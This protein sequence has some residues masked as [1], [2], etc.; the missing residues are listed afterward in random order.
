MR[1][2]ESCAIKPPLP[3]ASGQ[4]QKV[5]QPNFVIIAIFVFFA[6]NSFFV[7]ACRAGILALFRGNSL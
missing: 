2:S 6:V 5:I 4:K 7:A 3:F 1:A